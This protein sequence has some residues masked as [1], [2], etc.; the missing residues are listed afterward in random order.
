[1]DTTPPSI[2]A[3]ADASVE[4]GEAFDLSGAQVTD[5]CS[6]VTLD[7]DSVFAPTCG[8]AGVWTLTY[9]ATDACG[10]SAS[11]VQIITIVDTTPPS[12][13]AAADAEVECG[14]PIPA[15]AATADDSCGNATWS[16]SPQ[17]TEQ[18]GET[19]TMVRTYTATDD[20]GNTATATQTITVVDTTPPTITA[21]AD[22]TVECGQPIPAPAATADD[23]CGEATWTV[24]PQITEQCGGTY[25]MVRTY[26]ATDDCGN[27]ATDTQTITV[28][29]TTPPSITC[30]ADAIVNCANAN[31]SP[32]FT[33][34][35]TAEDECG[36]NV[37]IDYTDGAPEGSCPVV[38]VR[39]WTAVDACGN[40]SS[41]EQL[42]STVD[43][44]APVLNIPG[45]AIVECGN[46]TTPTFTGAATAVDACSGLELDYT[47]GP[48]TGDCPQTFERTWTAVDGC[49][50]SVSQVQIITI[51]DSTSPEASNVP[52]DVTIEC[53]EPTPDDAPSFSDICDSDLT[54][55][56]DEETNLL[57][58]GYEIVRTW[59]ATDDCGNSTVIVQT[60]TVTDTTAPSLTAGADQTVECGDAIPEAS[61]IVS[62]LCDDDVTVEVEEDRV[63]GCGNTYV[64]TYTITA[65][66]VCGNSSQATQTI[67]V[68]DTT[69]PE[70]EDAPSDVSV[71]C[72]NI[73][74]SVML[75]ATDNCDDDV[76]VTMTEDVSVGECPYTITRTWTAIDDCGNSAVTSQVITVV[77]NDAPVFGDYQVVIPVQC[78]EVDDLTIDVSDN[79][80]LDVEI[81][82]IDLLFSGNCLGTI[83]RTW[84]ATDACGNTAI[85]IQYIQLRDDEAPVI[86]NGPLNQTISCDD[87]VPAVSQDVIAL[88]NCDTDVSLSFEETIT[89]GDCPY[90]I[91][92][93]WTA[94]DDCGNITTF[95]QTITVVVNVDGDEPIV[96]AY[97][98]PMDGTGWFTFSVPTNLEGY[99]TLEIINNLGQRVDVIFEGYAVGGIEYRFNKDVFGWNEGVY[100]TRLVYKD[101]VEVTRFVKMN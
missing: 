96:N 49:Q 28:V 48:I 101:G 23:S 86:L 79:C 45:D 20:C 97:P 93:T 75:S 15:P 64:L 53:T 83:E 89:G 3:N 52:V 44:T 26:T 88:D 54:L 81:T 13:T 33:G 92:R 68:V 17:I 5:D 29:D 100:F 87:E 30:P 16:V 61:Y 21:A 2:T 47:D 58:C 36:G 34:S 24:T 39:T 19:Y 95:T 90:V 51:V 1:V 32:A 42:I 69:D 9:T 50:N 99:V 67:T 84:T 76:T 72:E 25:I 12:I 74:A 57:D 63:D 91:T 41:C 85:A 27:T 70:L 59:T 71:D 82:Y 37:Q 73:P 7:V 10:N 98:N 55:T 46:P 60:I 40:S 38:F 8:N 65:T 18:C 77:D 66:D 14:Q 56:D 4:C 80:D 6:T 31:Y 35:A 11:D 94:E 78:D 62:D 43:N 22:A